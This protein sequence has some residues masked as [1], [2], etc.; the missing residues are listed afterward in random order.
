MDVCPGN[1]VQF[2]LEFSWMLLLRGWP[3]IYIYV[4]MNMSPYVRTKHVD[5]DPSYWRF[6][7]DFEA[8]TSKTFMWCRFWVTLLD[9]QTWKSI[10]PVLRYLR[11]S[12]MA[13]CCKSSSSPPV[14]AALVQTWAYL[15]FLV[16]GNHMS[17]GPWNLIPASNPCKNW[18][19][20]LLPKHVRPVQLPYHTS[21]VLSSVVQGWGNQPA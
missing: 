18:L 17:L 8:E 13:S 15:G 2:P 12:S 21:V 4:D 6:L 16:A 19:I 5:M 14:P 7:Q 20:I 11:I 10:V 1:S 3:Q 9:Y